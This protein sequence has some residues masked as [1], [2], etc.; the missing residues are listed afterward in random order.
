MLSNPQPVLRM[1]SFCCHLPL[2]VIHHFYL[3]SHLLAY[4]TALETLVEKRITG[5]PVVDDDWKLVILLSLSLIFYCIICYV[6]PI[7]YFDRCLIADAKF[8]VGCSSQLL[9][10]AQHFYSHNVLFSL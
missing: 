6:P 9:G 5:F 8:L 10:S 1:V 7:Y 3:Y 2:S 4:V